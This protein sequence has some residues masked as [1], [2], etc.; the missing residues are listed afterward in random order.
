MTQRAYNFTPG[1][2]MLPPPVIRRIQEEWL[3]FNGMGASVIE[4]SHLIPEF[5]A[6]LF[7]TEDLLRELLEVPANYKIAF[8]H[9]GGQMQFALVPLNLIALKPARK[10]LYVETGLFSTRAIAE[11]RKHAAVEVIASSQDTGF[12]RIPTVDLAVLDPNA[13]YLHITTN[14]TMVGTQWK[15]YPDTGSLPLVGDITSEVLSRPVDVSRFGLLYAGAQK[16]LGVSGIAALIVREDLLAHGSPMLPKMLNYTQLVRDRS[17]S[18]TVNTFAIYVAN[19]MLKWVKTN[20]GVRA[21][22]A[23]NQEKAHL[24]YEMLDRHEGFYLPHA[25]P[26]H[27]SVMNVTFR[28]SS[29]ELEA[30]YIAEAKTAGLYAL[31]GH[32]VFGGVRASIYNAMPL[33]GVRALIDFS[34]TFVKTHG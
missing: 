25:H 15:D 26:A 20:G 6:L 21:M 24:L 29:P 3:D 27:R 14:N 31:K 10:A 33:E 13:S 16:N 1:P 18:N 2:S 4:I 23:K 9:G 5:K 32:Q 8:I 7:E 30:T 22:E 28:L 11:G 17:L 19:L 12:D 34:E